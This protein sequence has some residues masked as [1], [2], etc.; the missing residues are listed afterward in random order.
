MLLESLEPL[1]LL[2]QVVLREQ[3]ELLVLPVLALWVPLVSLEI[4]V[5]LEL[6]AQLVYKVWLDLSDLLV[7]LARL[8]RKERL[9]QQGI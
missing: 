9:E 4:K 7:L 5:L 3:R 8:D 2:D 6:L 1:A